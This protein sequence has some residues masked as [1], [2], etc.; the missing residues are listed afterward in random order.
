VR[1]VDGVALFVFIAA[2]MV[3]IRGVV[4]NRAPDPRTRQTIRFVVVPVVTIVVV[5]VVVVVGNVTGHS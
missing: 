5:L 3:G 4:V 2:V 1:L